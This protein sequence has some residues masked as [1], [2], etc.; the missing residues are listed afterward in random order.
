MIY[1]KLEFKINESEII[2][3][4]YIN[5]SPRMCT[6]KRGHKLTR[7]RRPSH[8]E[9]KFGVFSSQTNKRTTRGPSNQIK[10]IGRTVIQMSQF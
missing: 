4:I 1:D 3:I 2:I 8:D 9:E 5:F 6:T 10:S 7:W